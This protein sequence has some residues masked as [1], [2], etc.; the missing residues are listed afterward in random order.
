MNMMNPARSLLIAFLVSLA[1]A[2]A[3]HA[4]SVELKPNPQKPT[5]VVLS[6]GGGAELVFYR[7]LWQAMRVKTSGGKVFDLTDLFFYN[8]FKDDRPAGQEGYWTKPEN[9]DAQLAFSV[10]DRAGEEPGGATVLIEGKREGLTKRVYA[11]IYADQPAVYVVNRLTVETPGK[12]QDTH[13][14][15]LPFDRSARGFASEIIV[16]GRAGEREANA[17]G[18]EFAFAWLPN[19]G[20]SVAVLC[21]PGGM[22]KLKLKSP[23]RYV[24]GQ[25]GGEIHVEGILGQALSSG[26]MVD[27]RYIIR[28]DD[29]HSLEAVKALNQEL[30][31]GE[32]NHRFYPSR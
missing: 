25:K 10:V 4:A 27:L 5:E 22:Q 1:A 29:E 13:L 16:D 23:L 19:L 17:Q 28:W 11:T 24:A 7:N 2:E 26:E 18:R 3:A 20:T 31:G 15:Y 8:T 30:Q 6:T 14:V 12:V 9:W 21:P 32:L